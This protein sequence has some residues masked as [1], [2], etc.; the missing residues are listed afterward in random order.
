MQIDE[1]TRA[2]LLRA[3]SA[4]QVGLSPRETSR[5]SLMKVLRSI[6]HPEDPN[7]RAAA[8]FEREVS[9][10]VGKRLESG[11]LMGSW[12]IPAEVL[13]RPLGREAATRA[14]ATVPGSAG[15]YAVGVDN[16]GFID[17]LR[18][19][20]VARRL[21]ARLLSG[22]TGNVTFAAGVGSPSVTWQGGENVNVPAADQTLAQIAMTPKT[23]IT[24]T[25]VSEQLLRQTDGTAEA[26]VMA[27]LAA[28]VA[29]AVDY[30]AINGTGGAQ[31]IGIKNTAGVTTGQAADTFSYAK[32]LDFIKVAG[33][34]SAILGNPAWVTNTAG[35]LIAMQ[36]QRFAS[37]DSPLWTGSPLDGLLTGFPAAS[38][39]QLASGNIIFGSWDE[40]VIGEWGVL[41]LR[42][43]RGGTRF[44]QAQ[45]GIRAM[46][47]VDVMIRRPKAFVVGTNLS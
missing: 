43:D 19:R 4:I 30:A 7:A 15:G 26:F 24:V 23:A 9:D 28:G 37:T 36:R 31:P 35:A 17:I 38:S 18:A 27:D 29:V 33:E 21:G 12:Y 47:M 16:L 40:L 34:A 14:L 5:Y 32:A 2:A 11:S 45:V 20:S 46:W 42:A 1:T 25:D 44:N 6:V 13:T 3:A 22:L 41:E 10:T 8:A 39:E